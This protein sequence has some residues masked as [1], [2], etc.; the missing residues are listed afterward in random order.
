MNRLQKRKNILAI[1]P[2]AVFLL[3][4]LGSSLLAGDF[5]KV[6]VCTAFLIAGI[7]SVAISKGPIKERIAIFSRGAGDRNVM[8]MIWIFILAGAFAGSA[9]AIGAVD[10]TV[11]ATLSVVP[12]S[13]LYMG[14]FL[15]ACFISMSIGTSVGTIVALVPLGAGLA[16][17]IES[18]TAY[19][20]AVIVGGAFFG[21][22]LSFISDTTI[23]ATR[24]AGCEMRDKFKTN[25]LI[26]APAVIIVSVI[27]LFHGLGINSVVSG[28]ENLQWIKILP[29]LLIIILALLGKDV[30]IVLVCGI[31]ANA[32]IGW[33]TGVFDITGWLSSLGNGISGMSDLIIV[34][35]LAG[36]LLEMIKE[37]GGMDYFINRLSA[38]KM[39]SR[40]AQASIAAMVAFANICTANNTIAILT[41]GHIA[42][43]I[44]SHFGV[45]PRK[46]ASL[47]DTF[48]C[49]VQGMLPYGAQLLMASGLSGVAPTDIIPFLYY[50]FIMG[51]CAILSIVFDYPRF[52]KI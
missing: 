46:T 35:L 10:A 9:K 48:S 27:Y 16:A 26:I 2:L 51:A 15:T 38:K 33:A 49:L 32:I 12:P 11:A 17:E 22:N 21:D 29:Y 1:S 44:S 28:Q 41:T 23:A 24:A 8:L 37:M 47:L 34:T 14:L 42:K 7:Y 4:Y 20:T 39:G 52:K 19:M 6:P 25:I 43:N 18:S 31:T 50:P 36:G 45:D 5:Y 13:M 3:C 30:S 40:R